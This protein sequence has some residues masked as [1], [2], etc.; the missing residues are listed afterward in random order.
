MSRH[1]YLKN[2]TDDDYGNYDDEDDYSEE[3]A[4]GGQQNNDDFDDEVYD[5]YDMVIEAIPD[6]AL[7]EIYDVLTDYDFDKQQPKQQAPKQQQQQQQAKQTNNNN[8]NSKDDINNNYVGGGLPNVSNLTKINV[9]S[10]QQRQHSSNYKPS[11]LALNLCEMSPT[12]IVKPESLAISQFNSMSLY[13]RDNDKDDPITPY[14]FED[15][16]PD[17]IILFK[18]KQAFKP[19]GNQSKSIQKNQNVNQS[20]SKN[21]NTNQL[22]DGLKNIN[23]KKQTQQQSRTPYN[24]PTGSI[25]SEMAGS[26]SD[27]DLNMAAAANLSASQGNINVHKNVKQHSAS[28]KKELEELVHNSFATTNNKPHLNMVVIGH[29]DA[30]KSTTMGH[31][32]Y[33]LGYVDQR[34]ISKFERE[35]NNIGKGS[36]HFA[37]VLDEHQEERERGVTMDVCVRYFETEHRK[38]TLLDAPGHRDFVPNMISG[39]T[40]ADVAILLI[41]A[42]E[43]EAGFSSEGQTKEHALLAKSLGIMQLIVAIN[44]MD[45]VDWS[46]ERYNYITE[47]LKQFLVS[48]KFNEKNLYFMPIS[49]FKG[50]NLIEKIA[51]PR[52]SWYTGNTLVQQIDSFSVGE[53]LINK[54]FR[55]GVNDIYKTNSKGSVLVGGKIE[56]GVLGVGD[57]LLISPG[58]E[59]C[60]VKAIRRAHNDSDWAVGGDNIDLSLAIDVT[61]ILRLG[62]ILSDPEKPIQV[63]KRFLAQIVTFTLPL[64]ITNGYQAVFHAHSMEE[65]ATITKLLSLLDNSGGVSKKKPRCVSDGM[66]ALVE[67]QL[68]RLACLELYSSYRQLGRFTLRESGKTIAAGIITEFLDVDKATLNSSSSSTS[69]TTST[70]SSITSK[71]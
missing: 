55:M 36:F 70:S 28:R 60:T 17:D 15:P 67:V 65:P 52:C 68:T 7:E 19:S 27:S 53:R 6:I 41:N 5:V 34:T 43:F 58:N 69:T 9:V 24:T 22:S 40:Q 3:E 29:V 20:A 46:E 18:Q 10:R 48:A 13:D 31:L 38:I 4:V 47:T 54:P 21:I 71:N 57:K 11:E 63:S 59:L 12:K 66:T 14:N 30:G 32:L 45:L 49:G 8:N 61:N 26:P 39:T 23:I 2:L 51:D 33:K 50:D 64:P 37:W 16:S 35:A 62:S 25:S 1:R 56:A 44:K 42:S